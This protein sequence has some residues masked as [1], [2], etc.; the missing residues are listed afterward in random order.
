[1]KLR[2]L[3]H[4]P[5]LGQADGRR[6]VVDLEG[7]LSHYVARG[8]LARSIA[9]QEAG[10]INSDDRN[11]VEF[12]FARSLWQT[13]LFQSDELRELAGRARRASLEGRS[14]ATAR[15]RCM[16]ERRCDRRGPSPGRRVGGRGAEHHGPSAGDRDLV[17]VEQS[18]NAGGIARDKARPALME[19]PNVFRMQAV[20]NF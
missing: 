19:K 15:R 2:S 7:F 3:T 12:A 4:M 11:T 1:M 13:I 17:G 6:S 5:L 20:N 14:A 10:R 16:P 8:S 9:R 18:Q